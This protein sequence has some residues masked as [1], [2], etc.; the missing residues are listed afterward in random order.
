MLVKICNFLVVVFLYIFVL[1][2]Q[3]SHHFALY[4]KPY[5]H[6]QTPI[7]APYMHDEYF[8]KRVLIKSL[9]LFC[10]D[11]QRFEYQLL[12]QNIER[13]IQINSESSNPLQSKFATQRSTHQI[14][15]FRKWQIFA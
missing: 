2:E 12:W 9:H 15:C 13:N 6:Q 7:I 1:S 5:K 3:S 8:W 10:T 11:I 4:R 14:N